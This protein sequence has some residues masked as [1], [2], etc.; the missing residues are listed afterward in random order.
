[1]S[2]REA[3]S[4]DLIS[5]QSADAYEPTLLWED[6]ADDL[7]DTSEPVEDSVQTYLREIGQVGLL[8]AADEVTLARDIL[9]GNL[10][11]ETLLLHQHLPWSERGVLERTVAQG[12]EARRRLIQSNLRLV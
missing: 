1:M 7:E 8:T 5:E 6:P 3:I 11:R 2:E 4:D 9:S 10:A 12:D